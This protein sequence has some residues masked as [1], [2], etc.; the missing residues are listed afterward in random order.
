MT[1]DQARV[2]VSPD[3][4]HRHGPRGTVGWLAQIAGNQILADETNASRA[5]RL[6]AVEILGD[7]STEEFVRRIRRVTPADVQRVARMYLDLDR[8]LTVIVG[9]PTAA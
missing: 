9:P 6:S 2:I 7:V 1:P 4:V 8:A 5:A 3:P